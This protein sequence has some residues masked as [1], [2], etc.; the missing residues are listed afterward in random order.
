MLTT[1]FPEPWVMTTEQLDRCCCARRRL[2]VEEPPPEPLLL[3]IEQVA[4]L[5]NLGR[6]KVYEMAAAGDMPVTRIDG[7]LRVPRDKLLKWIEQR[8]NAARDDAA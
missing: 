8:T 2:W 6:T 1:I 3:T 5:L 4:Y 7:A